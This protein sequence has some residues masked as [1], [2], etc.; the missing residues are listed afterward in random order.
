MKVFI[1]AGGGGTRLYPLST[2]DCPKQFLKLIDEKSLLADTIERFSGLAPLSDITVITN[3]K[4]RELCERDL[5]ESGYSGVRILTEPCRR[6]TAP[7]YR[8]GRAFRERHHRKRAARIRSERPCHNAAR[9]ISCRNTA[10]GGF[11]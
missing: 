4:Y 11:V 9:S 8:T 2:E 5:A 7:G 3:E 6:N 1:L 10:R